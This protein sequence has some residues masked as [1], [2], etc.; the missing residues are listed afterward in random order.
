MSADDFKSIAEEFAEVSKKI[1]ESN[2]RSRELKIQKD[3]IAESILAFMQTKDIDECQLPG[4]GTIVRKKS[5]RTEALKPEMILSELTTALGD[6]AKANQVLQNMNSKRSV[7]ETEV[8]SL[9]KGGA[10][11]SGA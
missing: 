4:I 1:T 5:K 10:A 11:A 3:Q 2:K 6:E 8:I 7:K 9:T